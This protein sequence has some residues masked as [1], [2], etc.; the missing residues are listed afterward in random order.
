M[1]TLKK[2]NIVVSFLLEMAMLVALVYWG[3]RTGQGVWLKLLLGA[4]VPV[5]VIIVWGL[6]LAPKAANRAGSTFGVATTLI[7]FYLAAAALLLAKQPVLAA[8]MMIVAAI[9]RTLVVI[10]KQW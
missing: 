4:G 6:F 1:E 2:L 5:A 9:N 8:V 10:W 3:L 7:L